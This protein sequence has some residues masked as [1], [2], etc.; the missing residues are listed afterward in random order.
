[1]S[2]SSVTLNVRIKQ[3]ADG[4][5]EAIVVH[6]PRQTSRM[7]RKERTVGG[8]KRLPPRVNLFVPEDDL[9]ALHYSC[10]MA[11]QARLRGKLVSVLILDASAEEVQKIN[12]NGERAGRQFQFRM[13]E[14]AMEKLNDLASRTGL[15][16]AEIVRRLIYAAV[17]TEK[18]EGNSIAN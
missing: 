11:R 17:R 2:D 1:M 4:T 12:R 9:H 14:E 5:F 7:P 18:S 10:H 13:P 16:Q 8:F 15:T 6:P 3:K